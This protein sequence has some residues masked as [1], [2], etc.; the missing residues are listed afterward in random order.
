MSD[1]PM[2]DADDRNYPSPEY[3]QRIRFEGNECVV[4]YPEEYESLYEK[5][6][7]L[8]REL[9]A[10]SDK[11]N[12]KCQCQAWKDAQEYGADNESYGALVRGKQIGCGL[13]DAEFCPW[14]GGAV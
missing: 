4:M 14:C 7:Q 8:E 6:R 1:T 9:N 12:R 13:P 5:A 2:V 10:A 3:A 11:L